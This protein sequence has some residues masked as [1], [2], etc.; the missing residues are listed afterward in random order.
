MT[1][2]RTTAVALGLAAICASGLAA[3]TQ[4]TK[5]TTKTKV[6]ISGGKDVTVMGCLEQRP[7]G[8]YMLTE[9]RANRGGETSRYALVTSED[10][11]K[12]VGERVEIQGKAVVSGDGKLTVESKTNT[13]VENGKDQE[14]KTKRESTSGALALPYLGVKS[15]KTFSSYCS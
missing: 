9:V 5:T 13:E 3:Q 7:N 12:H 15:I 6:E 8:E 2:I 4:E 11:S 14:S 10:L 1:M